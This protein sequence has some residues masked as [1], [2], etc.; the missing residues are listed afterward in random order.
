MDRATSSHLTSL[1]V[2]SVMY[3]CKSDDFRYGQRQNPNRLSG[4]GFFFSRVFFFVAVRS[5]LYLKTVF[6]SLS[7]VWG[8]M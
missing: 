4:R 8:V 1:T 2:A 5:H 7:C 3:E 6:W